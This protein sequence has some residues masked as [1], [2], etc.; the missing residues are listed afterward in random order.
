MI[1]FEDLSDAAHDPMI[2][3]LDF[4]SFAA[5]D[6]L[7]L[8]LQ[9]S[10]IVADYNVGNR[11]PV[12]AAWLQGDLR[13]GLD[14][15]EKTGDTLMRR[16]AALIW[17]EYRDLRPAIDRIAPGSLADIGCGYAI[18]E[19]FY[20]RDFPGRLL[21]IDTESTEERHFGFQN[22]GA[23]YSNLE[24]AADFLKDNG[25][26]AE[27][28]TCLNPGRKDLRAQE[29]VDLAVSFVSCGFH[30]PCGT[31]L[32]FFRD[33]VAPDGHVIVDLRAR[34]AKR[35]REVLGSLGTVTDLGTIA[36]GSGRRV[37]LRKMTT[38]ID[39]DPAASSA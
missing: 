21:L 17:L 11:S 14:L 28:I 39:D 9:R 13:P 12:V 19:L 18:F 30:Y 3:S 26:R 32:D 22:R 29:Q 10:Q 38:L 35:E 31:Y 27:D 8:I 2:V 23:A 33:G 34:K 24:V 5:T 36:N 15:I 1:T 25:V 20:W 4:S 6:V 37:Q 16:A 7:N